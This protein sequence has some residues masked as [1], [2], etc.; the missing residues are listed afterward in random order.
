MIEEWFGR[1]VLFFIALTDKTEICVTKQRSPKSVNSYTNI[2][3]KAPQEVR[4]F[5]DTDSGQRWDAG[6]YQSVLELTQKVA[7]APT[8][9]EAERYLDMLL[10]CIVD[11]GP[12][13]VGFAPSID[14]AADA[15]Q[16]RRKRNFIAD[17]TSRRQA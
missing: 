4:A 15:M 16:R 13:G 10:W 2:L 1:N 17:K 9:P 12:L 11:S 6:W 5:A 3:A 8:E 14:A 7:D